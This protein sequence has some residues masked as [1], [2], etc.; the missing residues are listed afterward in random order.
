MT[1]KEKMLAGELYRSW[2]EELVLERLR[3]R[4]MVYLLNQT[5]E[6]EGH[7][8]EQLIRDLFGT[9]GEKV[10]LETPFHCDYGYNIHVG[11]DFYANF[12]C[13]FLDVCEIRIGNRA[14]LGPNVQLY[15]ATHPLNR[16]QRASG[17]ESGKPIL[18]GHDVWIGG[19]AII[20]PGITIG[21]NVVIA[22]GAV[23]TKDL[24]D[25]VFAGGNPARIIRE[26][27]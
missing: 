4:Q 17:L 22:S 7:Y 8:R 20:N 21:D 12:N 10:S 14:L 5:K 6:T 25:N 18:I 27:D 26:V 11:E 2:D 19:G 23:V 13:V 9:A 24:P 1:E 15:T 3:A 16:E